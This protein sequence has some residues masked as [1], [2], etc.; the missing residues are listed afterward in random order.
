MNMA[1]EGDHSMLT[2]GISN[3]QPLLLLCQWIPELDSQDLQILVSDWL[4]RTCGGGRRSRETCVKAGMVSAL[5][6]TLGPH[7]RLH[8]QCASNLLW[9]LQALG[10]LSIRPG[11]LRQLLKLLRTDG[12]GASERQAH[13]YCAQVIRALSAMAR[14]E[15]ASSAL[16]YFDLTPPMAGIMVPTI[17]KW[18]G[19]GFAFHAW[20]CLDTEQHSNGNIGGKGPKR[21]QLYRSVT[22]LYTVCPH[23]RVRVRDTVTLLYTVRPHSQVRV[24]DTVTHSHYIPRSGLETQ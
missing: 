23:S 19:N 9:L 8:H 16:Q 5:L 12:D 18:P 13:P 3:E 17:Q 10:S 7:T 2:V 14:S 24:R 15:E 20:L 6:E 11:E 22:S 4:R 1:V 21:K